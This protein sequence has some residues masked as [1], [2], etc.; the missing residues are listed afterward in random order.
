[1]WLSFWSGW[2]ELDV[3]F[4]NNFPEHFW[5]LMRKLVSSQVVL[6]CYNTSD[7]CCK[8][9]CNWS[10][11]NIVCITFLYIACK[12]MWLGGIDTNVQTVTK[13]SAK[14]VLGHIHWH[15]INSSEIMISWC[16]EAKAKQLSY[17]SKW[18][19]W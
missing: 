8:D 2:P 5:F 10:G 7:W 13:C 16:V 15:M 4:V 18:L 11:E 14:C 6:C 19:Q 9:M 1:M 17:P 12:N 3:P